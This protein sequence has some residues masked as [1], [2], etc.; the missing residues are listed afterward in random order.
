MNDIEEAR[1]LLTK[2]DVFFGDYEDEDFPKLKQT[3]NM[4]DVWCWACADGEYVSDEELPEVARLYRAYG[5]CGI[6]YWVSQKNGGMRSEFLDINRF[7]DFVKHEEDFIK[8]VPDW[9][10]RAYKQMTY[11]LGD[12]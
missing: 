7:I 9:D 5:Y 3:L 1:E 6:L 11:T 2:A 8:E 4:N 10:E 12:V